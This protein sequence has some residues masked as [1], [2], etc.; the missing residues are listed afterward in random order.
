MGLSG[1]VKGLRLNRWPLGGPTQTVGVT[2]CTSGPLEDGLF[3]PGG[4]VLTLGLWGREGPGGAGRLWGGLPATAALPTE[5]PEATL[6]DVSLELE[7][8]PLAA[9]GLVF[10]LGRTQNAP[11]LQLQVSKEQVSRAASELQDTLGDSAGSA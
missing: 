7:V 4:G 3:F 9:T 1:C 11:Y 10:H 8:R 6:P 5:G 2:P